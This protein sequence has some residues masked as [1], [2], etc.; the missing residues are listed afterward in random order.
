MSKTPNQMTEHVWSVESL[1]R[2]SDCERC[3]T[4]RYRAFSGELIYFTPDGK[5]TGRAVWGTI[6]PPCTPPAPAPEVP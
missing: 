2:W 5:I 4:A 1:Q 6:N 3:D